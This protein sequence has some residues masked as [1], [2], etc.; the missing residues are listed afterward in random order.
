MRGFWQQNYGAVEGV[1]ETAWALYISETSRER[2]VTKTTR[3]AKRIQGETDWSE[4][5]AKA[6]FDEIVRRAKS[7][8]QYVAVS[9][10]R[11]IAIIEAEVLQRLISLDGSALPLVDFLESLHAPGLDLERDA[12]PGRDITL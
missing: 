11:R 2:K 12:D 7:A 3:S 8:P 6:K 9:G 10:G 1:A 5:D 4:A